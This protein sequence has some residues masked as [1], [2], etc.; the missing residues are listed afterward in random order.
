MESPKYVYL[1]TSY[2][3]HGA[4]NVHATLNRDAVVA[5][6]DAAFKSIFRSDDFVHHAARLKEFLSKPDEILS[7]NRNGWNCSVGWGGL[8]F[9]VIALE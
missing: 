6:H 3:E 2:D 8:M 1:L 9:Y 4:E 5:L 7:T